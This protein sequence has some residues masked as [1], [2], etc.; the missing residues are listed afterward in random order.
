MQDEKKITVISNRRKA[1]IGV[2][3]ILYILMKRK[4][5]EMHVSG[6]DIFKTR[7]TLSELVPQLDERFMP[8]GKAGCCRLLFTHIRPPDYVFMERTPAKRLRFA[9]GC[10]KIQTNLTNLPK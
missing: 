3:S 4:I 9:G 1:E 2:R 6:G 10:D 7:T 5:A 8:Y